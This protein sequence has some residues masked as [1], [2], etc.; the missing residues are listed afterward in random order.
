MIK[1]PEKYAIAQASTSHGYG[2]I[3]IHLYE[4]MPY[5]RATVKISCQTGGSS[6]DA[7]P[8]SYAWVHGLSKDY[9]VLTLSDLKEGA[10]VLRK[11][12]RG[13]IA[14]AE[15]DRR[16]GLGSNYVN[17]FARYALRILLAA[18]VKKVY[19]NPNI[20]RSFNDYKELPCASMPR[21]AD[22]AYEWLSALES[23]LIEQTKG[24][25]CW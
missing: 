13:L 4:T 1:K 25:A 14:A 16:N 19:V 9:G 2:H 24:K 6:S 17:S 11:I 22:D 12:D 20:G 15:D 3:S 8:Q 23:L 21:D 5:S 7:E 18:G 10:S